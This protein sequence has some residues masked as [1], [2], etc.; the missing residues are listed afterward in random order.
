M[1]IMNQMGSTIPIYMD[2]SFHQWRP[3]PLLVHNTQF[4]CY[5]TWKS[6]SALP[7]PVPIPG[8]I[9]NHSSG[10]LNHVKFSSLSTQLSFFCQL[11][12]LSFESGS[13]L[14]S[15]TASLIHS[16][17]PCGVQRLAQ[18]RAWRM[19]AEWMHKAEEILLRESRVKALWG[20]AAE[21][22]RT[23]PRRSHHCLAMQTELGEKRIW[24]R[25]Q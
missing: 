13:Q 14:S 22:V 24:V 17:S 20:P 5:L 6:P 23:R 21:N 4:L 10:L 18:S 12:C 25:S 7:A 9:R 19:S 8:W 11:L 2:H 1:V 16:G 15:G 3:C